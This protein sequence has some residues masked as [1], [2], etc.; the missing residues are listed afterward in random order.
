MK[1]TDPVPEADARAQNLFYFSQTHQA[2]APEFTEYW[3]EKGGVEQFG[4]PI[5]QPAK[6]KGVLSQFFQRAVFEYH[7]ELA[8]SGNTVLLRLIG[9][10]LAQGRVFAPITAIKAPL[11]SIYF[12]QTGHSLGSAFLTFWTSTGGL[13]VYGYPI[14]EPEIEKAPDGHSYTVQYFERNRLELHPGGRRHALRGATG[15]AGGCPVKARPLVEIGELRF[16]RE[17]RLSCW[18]SLRP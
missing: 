6:I 8:N 4:Y 1:I 14:S 10:E 11:G 18:R 15:V 9:R 16:A 17:F 13:A 7:P 3:I 12:P 2:I 5:S